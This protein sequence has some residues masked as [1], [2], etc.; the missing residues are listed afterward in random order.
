MDEHLPEPDRETMEYLRHIVDEGT[1]GAT[2]HVRLIHELFV[3]LS[4]TIPQPEQLWPVLQLTRE[5][6]DQTRGKDTPI[7][8]N[9]MRWLLGDL[10]D[11]GTTDLPR[12]LSQRA[13]EWEAE[14][15]QR[16]NRLLETGCNILADVGTILLFDYSSTVSALVK[17]VYKTRS[18]PPT[19][20]IFESRAIDGGWPY[21]EDLTRLRVPVRF[22][23]DAAIEFECARADAVL[24]GVE[25]LRC[26]GSLIN[27]I[28]SRLIARVACQ[29]GAAV[30]GC[31]DLFKLDLHSYKGVFK[32]PAVKDFG[33]V[34]LGSRH[35]DFGISE[36]VRVLISTSAPELE[37]VPTTQLSGYLTDH[38]FVPPESIWQLG[39]DV[40]PHLK[41]KRDE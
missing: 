26:D 39:R 30:Y 33:N 20:V 41:E 8:S 29:H 32:Q 7:I 19:V 27:T 34:L 25:S 12:V 16:M 4:R 23:V 14:T 6:I 2:N 9:S 24:L 15:A 21:V 36:D 11:S 10:N 1:L 18:K 40:F 31:C 17:H 37:I 3:H 35:K 38:G 13:E 22:T 5:F 28:G